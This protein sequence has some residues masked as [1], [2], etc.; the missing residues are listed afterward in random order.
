VIFD[1]RKDSPGVKFNDADLIG[2]PIRVTVSKR[3]VSEG[4]IE[5][6]ERSLDEKVVVAWDDAVSYIIEVKEKLEKE[7]SAKVIEMPYKE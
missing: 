4:T 7:L 1:D 2:I 5:V 3:A 6:K